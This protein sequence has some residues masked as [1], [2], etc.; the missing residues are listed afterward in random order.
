MT[1]RLTSPRVHPT[2]SFIDDINESCIH[3]NAKIYINSSCDTIYRVKDDIA[4]ISTNSETNPIIDDKSNFDSYFINIQQ[5]IIEKFEVDL[6]NIIYKYYETS[7]GMI[8]LNDLLL[9]YLMFPN[10]K[11]YIH[12]TINDED[13]LEQMND[14]T[15]L[16]HDDPFLFI[17]YKIIT[18]F[19]DLFS[20]LVIK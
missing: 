10:E 3:Q 20:A 6:Y 16:V 7:C 11:D 1:S 4:K 5:T 13:N 15:S 17:R 18:D 12:S 9:G 19:I 2:G 14:L 8:R